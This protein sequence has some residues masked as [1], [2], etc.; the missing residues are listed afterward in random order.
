MPFPNRHAGWAL[1]FAL[2]PFANL[3]SAKEM[4][5]GATTDERRFPPTYITTEGHRDVKPE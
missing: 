2:V 3:I 5:P 4:A 1:A